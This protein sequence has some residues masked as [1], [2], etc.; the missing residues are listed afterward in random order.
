MKPDRDPRSGPFPAAQ[1]RSEPGPGAVPFPAAQ[2]RS[3]PGPDAVGRQPGQHPAGLAVGVIGAGRAGTALGVALARAGHAVVAASAVSDASVQRARA[4]FPGVV[5]AEPAQ[6]LRLA[7]LALLTVPDDVLPGLVAGLAATEAPLA[8]RM[9]AHASGRYGIAVLEPAAR[10]GGLPLALHPVMTFT[11]RADD[12]DRLRGTCFGVTAPDVL[13][14]AAEALVIEMGGE[15]VFIAEEHRDLYHAALASAANH[16]ITLVAEAADLLRAAGVADPARMLGPLL[17][18]A[19]DNALRFG[20]AGLTGPVARGDADTVAAHVRAIEATPSASRAAVAAYVAMA[21]LT[22]DR[23][24]AAGLLKP[25][26][27]ERLLDVL[28]GRP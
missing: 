11:G 5:I 18:A 7:D 1:H 26:D 22:A 23:A 24:L 17:S 10:L 21:R 9:I 16:L 2:H 20:D 15:P 8:G 27:A 13:R 3:E 6:V 25:A 28:G 14:T 4:N 12:V 19:L